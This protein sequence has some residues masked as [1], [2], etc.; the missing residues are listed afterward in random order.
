VNDKIEKNRVG[1]TCNA[2][3]AGERRVTVFG[4]KP[5]GK[6]PLRK[7]WCRWEDNIKRNL[8]TVVFEDMDWIELAHD[9]DRWRALLNAVVNLRVP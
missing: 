9:R 4:V 2:Y 1:G 3:G 8:Q 6:R 5:E 7:P